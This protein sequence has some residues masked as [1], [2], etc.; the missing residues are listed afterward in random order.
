MYNFIAILSILVRQFMLPNPFECFGV[1]AVLYNLIAGVLLTPISYKIVGLVYTRGSAPALG[2]FL[3]LIVYSSLTGVLCILGKFCF[4]W[5][6][7][8]AMIVISV[9][10]LYLINKLRTEVLWRI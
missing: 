5:W 10:V 2:S 4:A 8:V 6:A 1:K 9:L 3:Y 7:I